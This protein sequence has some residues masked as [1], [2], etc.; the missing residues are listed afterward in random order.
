MLCRSFLQ[1]ISPALGSLPA[2]RRRSAAGSALPEFIPFALCLLV[3]QPANGPDCVHE[4]KLD[5]WRVQARGED[6]KATLRTRKGLDLEFDAGTCSSTGRSDPPCRQRLPP[7]VRQE[8]PE[9]TPGQ[10]IDRA[11]ARYSGARGEASN[12]T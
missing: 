11:L 1:A 12:R 8:P 6:G 2:K 9:E 3:E 10:R 7:V 5:G 4:V